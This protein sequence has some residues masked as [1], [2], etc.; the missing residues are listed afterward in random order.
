MDIRKNE[1]IMKEK[2]LCES[3]NN[4]Q[5]LKHFEKCPNCFS[6]AYHS[7]P[8]LLIEN[9]ILQTQPNTNNSQVGKM[10]RFSKNPSR[11]NG[12]VY[13]CPGVYQNHE[14]KLEKKHGMD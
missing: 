10:G 7:A 11:N 5:I 2:C 3:C 8:K 1:D 9:S 4:K 6:E 13:P 12:D 14:N